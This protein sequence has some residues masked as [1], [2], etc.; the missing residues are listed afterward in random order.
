MVLTKNIVLLTTMFKLREDTTS[1]RT[2]NLTED[3]ALGS[4]SFTVVSRDPDA[5]SD[6]Y[7]CQSIHLISCEC[8]C[9]SIS[10]ISL[11]PDQS[12]IFPSSLKGEIL[13]YLQK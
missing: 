5:I 9:I 1:N 6:R 4:H 12:L 7:G 11:P 8:P 3:F 2:T 13:Q 10:G